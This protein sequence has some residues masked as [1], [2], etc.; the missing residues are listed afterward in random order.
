MIVTIIMYRIN[1]YLKNRKIFD[2][3]N[4]E[5]RERDI[6]KFISRFHVKGLVFFRCLSVFGGFVFCRKKNHLG[7]FLN[8][9]FW[10]GGCHKKTLKIYSLNFWSNSFFYLVTFGLKLINQ[11]FFLN[12]VFEF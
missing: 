6:E 11:K 1:I 7:I 8:T 3:T 4:K 10:F 5:R 9:L 2:L 12:K